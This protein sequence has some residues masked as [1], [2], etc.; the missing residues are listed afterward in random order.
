[1]GKQ[2]KLSFAGKIAAY[3][4]LMLFSIFSVYPILRV[5]TI[6]LRPGDRLL[7]KSLAL[8]PEQATLATYVKLFTEQPFLQ[9]MGNSL[10][11]SGAVIDYHANVSFDHVAAAVIY[12]VD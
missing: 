9:W 7:S 11:I 4:I 6:S 3:G 1:M 8:I 2:G 10:I 5:I 12:H